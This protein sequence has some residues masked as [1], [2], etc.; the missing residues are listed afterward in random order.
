MRDPHKKEFVSST[1]PR[2]F[3]RNWFRPQGPQPQ[4][5]D[6]TDT[7]TEKYLKQKLQGDSEP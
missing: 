7:T 5:L 2:Y 1:V 6:C 3:E 4:E